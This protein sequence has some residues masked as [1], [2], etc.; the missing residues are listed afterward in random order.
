MVSSRGRR[1]KMQGRRVYDFR[2]DQ[3]VLQK[4]V[5]EGSDASFCRRVCDWG[6]KRVCG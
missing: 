2:L 3:D 1:V 5:D 6:G 4:E